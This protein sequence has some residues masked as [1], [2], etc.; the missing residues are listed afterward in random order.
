MT[1]QV[2]GRKIKSSLGAQ[3]CSVGGVDGTR[4]RS[5]KGAVPVAAARPHV[6]VSCALPSLFPG[7]PGPGSQSV[8]SP[9]GG[10]SD[11]TNS[12]P[13]PVPGSRRRREAAAAAPLSARECTFAEDSALPDGRATDVH[14]RT[15]PPVGNGSRAPTSLPPTETL[16]IPF[17]KEFYLVQLCRRCRAL[18]AWRPLGAA[19]RGASPQSRGYLHRNK[20]RLGRWGLLAADVFF[21]TARQSINSSYGGLTRGTGFE[22]PRPARGTVFPV[23]AALGS[24]ATI[25][26]A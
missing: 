6:L 17:K 25:R 23:S 15:T 19:R 20:H 9:G 26:S 7:K 10:G 4:V 22:R 11:S 1:S 2:W 24:L 18:A 5:R 14:A 8:F 3:Q 12:S 13:P 21:W 16:R